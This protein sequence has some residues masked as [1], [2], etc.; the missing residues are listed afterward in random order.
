M[1][2]PENLDKRAKADALWSLARVLYTQVQHNE[3]VKYAKESVNLNATPRKL[4]QVGVYEV[5]SGST[6]DGLKTIRNAIRE[7][8][9]LFAL[10]LVEPDLVSITRKIENMLSRLSLDALANAKKQH[11]E[12]LSILKKIEGNTNQSE[13]RRLLA[14]VRAKV[15]WVGKTLAKSSYSECIMGAAHARGLIDVITQVQALNAH[16]SQESR[17]KNELAAARVTHKDQLARA[18]AAEQRTSATN[19]LLSP[20]LVI[21]AGYVGLGVLFNYIFPSPFADL[22]GN[23]LGLIIWP[24][25]FAASFVLALIGQLLAPKAP[26]LGWA[27]GFLFVA[28]AAIFLVLRAIASYENTARHR[29]QRLSVL[30]TNARAE[31]SRLEHELSDVANSISRITSGVQKT[32]A[33]M[34]NG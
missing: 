24:L 6:E 34:T 32:L 22:M 9:R 10:A 31:V 7:D 14:E 27:F 20:P 33:E 3:S 1:T 26:P 21:I 11:E 19:K 23:P 16:Y 15:E 4:F 13:C 2:L 5:L 30:A 18:T 8:H 29:N 25:I 17:S 12:S 28:G